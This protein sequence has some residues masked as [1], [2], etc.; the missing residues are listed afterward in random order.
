MNFRSLLSKWFR[1]RQP[2]VPISVRVTPDEEARE[3]LERRRKELEYRPES[4]FHR[5][6][7]QGRIVNLAHERFERVRRK[8]QIERVRGL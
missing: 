2:I 3:I 7:V 5:D 6:R 8:E 4:G 1:R